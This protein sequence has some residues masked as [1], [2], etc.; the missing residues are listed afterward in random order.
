MLVQKQYF[1][2]KRLNKKIKI[3]LSLPNVMQ[4]LFR[5]KFQVLYTVFPWI[6]PSPPRI[7]FKLSNKCPPWLTSHP[8]LPTYSA[9]EEIGRNFLVYFQLTFYHFCSRCISCCSSFILSFKTASLFS[10]VVVLWKLWMK[11]VYL[12]KKNSVVSPYSNFVFSLFLSFLNSQHTG[13][14]IFKNKKTFLKIAS[15]IFDS[16]W[17]F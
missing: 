16:L 7:C 8:T 10:F 5:N 2:L 9:E 17:I 6:S 1:H 3:A 4:I 11:T 14:P 15:V 13:S 12:L